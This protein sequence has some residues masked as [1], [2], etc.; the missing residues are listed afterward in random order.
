MYER[1][2]IGSGSPR[3]SSQTKFSA[4]G[5]FIFFRGTDRRD[6]GQIQ[7]IEEEREGNKGE[8]R[9]GQWRTDEGYFPQRDKGLLRPDKRRQRWQMG[10]W[11]FVKV[12]GETLC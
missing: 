3:L 1:K 11:Q 9:K 2:S 5:R 10:K 8:E 6:K 7:G 12:N 4:Q